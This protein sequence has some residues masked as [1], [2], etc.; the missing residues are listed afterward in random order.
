M[1]SELKANLLKWLL[2]LCWFYAGKKVKINVFETNLTKSDITL[3]NVSKISQ[4]T[5]PL[6]DE[7]FICK[8]KELLLN[9]LLPNIRTFEKSFEKKKPFEF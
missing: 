3:Q 1:E 4:N 5:H 6:F 7:K 9:Y 2:V 8:F